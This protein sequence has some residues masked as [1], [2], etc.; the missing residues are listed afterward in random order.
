MI[1]AGGFSAYQMVFGSN[2]AD[3]SGSGE[4]G[5]NLMFSLDTSLSG[6]FAQLWGPRVRAQVA[7]LR[8]VANS[9]LRRP[10]ARNESFKC[11]D[12]AIGGS[13]PFL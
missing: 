7:A 13:A 8:E 6:Q 4:R 5:R 10:L 3:F 9:I 12:L 1:S 2:P 11:A